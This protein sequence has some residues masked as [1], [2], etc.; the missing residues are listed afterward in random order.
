MECDGGFPLPAPG[1]VPLMCTS[2][3]CV[4]H[5]RRSAM[6]LPFPMSCAGAQGL[7]L[8]THSGVE[9]STAF[10]PPPLPLAACC[11]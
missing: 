2:S 11:A 3:H 10:F 4:N 5:R 9:S 6:F 1:P 7:Y 8:F